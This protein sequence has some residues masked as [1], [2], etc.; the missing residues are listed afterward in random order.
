[1]SFIME[2]LQNPVVIA[3]IVGAII[4]SV[5][6]NI[7]LANF[8]LSLIISIIVMGIISALMS[9]VREKERLQL[10][11]DAKNEDLI[12]RKKIQMEKEAKEGKCI[13]CTQ[14]LPADAKE[15]PNCGYKVKQYKLKQSVEEE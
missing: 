12:D 10:A 4:L 15:C 5:I 3:L 11:R 14:S 2:R 7:F 8:V 6:L 13:S 9:D 1:M